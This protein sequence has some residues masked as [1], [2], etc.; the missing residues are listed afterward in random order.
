MN[1]YDT[2]MD[3]TEFGFDVWHGTMSPL[4]NFHLIVLHIYHDGSKSQRE[5]SYNKTSFIHSFLSQ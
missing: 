1:S 2:V 4:Y 3:V 5:K